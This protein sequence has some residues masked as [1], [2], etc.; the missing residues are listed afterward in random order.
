MLLV[1]ILGITRTSLEPPKQIRSFLQIIPLIVRVLI[2]V[3]RMPGS[4]GKLLSSL[5]LVGG[6]GMMMDVL[7]LV[8]LVRSWPAVLRLLE[9]EG[10]LGLV[11]RRRRVGELLQAVA[12]VLLQDAGS[13]L[14]AVAVVVERRSVRGQYSRSRLE[15]R[16]VLLAIRA[17]AP[18]HAKAK[19]AS[20]RMLYY[21]S[22]IK[23]VCD[24]SI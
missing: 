16:C 14:D 11:D 1:P 15:H 24:S 9:W 10:V 23:A 2:I 18:R 20:V 6:D 7:L 13:V 22:S 12:G 3:R 19:N 4:N 5:V 21:M 17:F 8:L